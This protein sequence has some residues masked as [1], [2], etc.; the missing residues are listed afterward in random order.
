M[1]KAV[2][3]WLLRAAQWY[4]EKGVSPYEQAEIYFQVWGMPRE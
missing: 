4:A 3:K 1:N 2:R